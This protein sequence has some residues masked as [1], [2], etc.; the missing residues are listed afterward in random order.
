MLREDYSVRIQDKFNSLKHWVQNKSTSLKHWIQSINLRKRIQT[1]VTLKRQGHA[2]VFFLIVFIIASVCFREEFLFH[3]G[4]TLFSIAIVYLVMKQSNIELKETTEKQINAFVTNLQ[5]VCTELRN[6]SDKI[7]TLSVIMK[8]VQEILGETWSVS[9]EATAKREI[10]KRER[11]ETIKPQLFIRLEL[12]GFNF[13]IDLRH[14]HLIV[15]NSGSDALGTVVRIGDWQWGGYNIEPYRPRDIDI[16]YIN[17]YRG[18]SLLDISIETRDI[19][20]NHYQGYIRV[21][22]VAQL[23]QNIPIP[24]VEA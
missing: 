8:D 14:Y 1:N 23:G 2:Y 9:K 24:L 5:M 12:R 13:I 11:K 22:L 15:S 19:D 7:V 18:V 21:S 20:R 17:S 10:E 6:V 3:V 4:V 16:G